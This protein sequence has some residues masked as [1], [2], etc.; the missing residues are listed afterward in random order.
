[1]LSAD[2]HQ[3]P[4]CG[5]GCSRGLGCNQSQALKFLWPQRDAQT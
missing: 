1:M 5:R 3:A 4:T 2:I